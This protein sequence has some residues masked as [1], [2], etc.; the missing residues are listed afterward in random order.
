MR[1]RLASYNIR[2][3]VGLDWRR[4]PSR[5]LRV[6]RALD[7][8]VVALQEADKRLGLRPAAVPPEA[9]ARETELRAVPLGHSPVSLGWHGN[10]VLVRKSLEVSGATCLE[11]PGIE[12]RGC[13]IVR[14]VAELG[15]LTLV[16]V[17]LGLRRRCRR[18]Q[19][20]RILRA[21]GR[22]G[23]ERSVI[24]GD[25]NEWSPDRGVE[26]LLPRFRV[27]SPGNSFHASQPVAPLDRFALG[28]RV[29]LID[30]GVEA[31]PIARRA[32][33]HLPVWTEVELR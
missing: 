21:L 7:A 23:A 4:D 33:D 24:L 2:K 27:V 31:G 26:P 17:H 5:T 25:F 29:R 9:I 10:A 13:V 19:F 30:S 15:E 1:L 11:L 14:L 8:D 6:I 20:A 32:S 18:L 12:P 22:A 16:A 28:A 3:A